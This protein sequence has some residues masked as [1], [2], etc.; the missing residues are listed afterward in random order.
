MISIATK[1][2]NFDRVKA[3]A[4]AHDSVSMAIGVHPHAAGESGITSA[5]Q[6]LAYCMI[7]TWLG[8]ARQGWITFTITVQ[9]TRKRRI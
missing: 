8:S 2:E 9:W 5:D 1:L 6:L 7:L 3:I 4:A